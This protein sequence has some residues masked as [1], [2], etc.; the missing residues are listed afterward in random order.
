MERNKQYYNKEGVQLAMYPFRTMN[1]TQGM[2]GTFSHRGRL[3]IDDAGKDVGICDVFAPFDATVAWITTGSNRSGVLITSDNPVLC[4][5]GKI[6]HISFYAF[7]DNDTSDLF[8]G[9]KLKQGEVFY[10]EGTEGFATGNHVHYQTGDQPYTGGSPLFA[11]AFGGM[12]LRGECSPVDVFWINDTIIRRDFGYAW[13]TAEEVFSEPPTIPTTQRT[14]TVRQGQTLSAIAAM[15][16]PVTVDQL[17]QVNRALIGENRNL[18]KAGQVLVIPVSSAPTPTPTPVPTPA[19]I[20]AATTTTYQVVRGDTLDSIARRFSGTTIQQIYEAN[21]VLIGPDRDLIKVG[22][23]LTI[24]NVQPTAPVVFK[25]GDRVIF[26]GT[27]YANGTTRVP[28]WVKARAHTIKQVGSDRVLLK[29]I[30][31][32]VLIKDIIKV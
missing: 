8:I 1:V 9:K 2:N 21:R 30:N 13:K 27:F 17:Y 16:P 3:A 10:Q 5:D 25:V 12:T 20:P 31:S 7:H 6:K 23:V 11:N 19:P 26:N 32:W 14:H 15:Y 28:L 29:E 4:A 18:I 24:P 22:M